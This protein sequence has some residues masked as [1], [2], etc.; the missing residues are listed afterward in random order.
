MLRWHGMYMYAV[1]NFA[2]IT[3]RNNKETL[4][5]L[6]LTPKQSDVTLKST[7]EDTRSNPGR[8]VH[9]GLASN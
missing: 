6:S 4:P 1:Q 2:H 3:E 9:D 8:R 7:G 5:R